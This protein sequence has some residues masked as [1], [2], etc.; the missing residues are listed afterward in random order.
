M[1]VICQLSW[2]P[3]SLNGS[4][5]CLRCLSR[6]RRTCFA[7]VLPFLFKDMCLAS[8]NRGSTKQFGKAWETYRKS[9]S[10]HFEPCLRFVIEHPFL[11]KV[12][13]HDGIF[14]TGLSH[15]LGC[16]PLP[17]TV[18]T[19]NIIFLVGDPNLNLHLPLLLGGGTTQAISPSRCWATCLSSCPLSKHL[20]SLSPV[21][22]PAAKPGWIPGVVGGDNSLLFKAWC[23]NKLLQQPWHPDDWIYIFLIFEYI[24]DELSCILSRLF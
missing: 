22:V 24:I 23:L 20:R 18:T 3:C 15:K 2:R 13:N 8:W 10:L 7:T 14:P 5:G 12:V 17:V 9:I 16:P 19:G 6:L 21:H 1:T 11:H 4:T